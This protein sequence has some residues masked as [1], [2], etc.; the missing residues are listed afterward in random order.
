MAEP[1]IVNRRGFDKYNVWIS[2]KIFTAKDTMGKC[3][4]I[5]LH[6]VGSIT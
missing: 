3:V 2:A 5:L 1:A 6:I 4:E